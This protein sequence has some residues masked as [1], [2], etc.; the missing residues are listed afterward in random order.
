MKETE[1]ISETNR[2]WN[3]AKEN[4][5]NIA[6]KYLKELL[7]KKGFRESFVEYFE[8]EIEGGFYWYDEINTNSFAV[9]FNNLD[10]DLTLYE[11]KIY[12]K[13]HILKHLEERCDWAMDKE[14]ESALQSERG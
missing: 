4:I 7:L 13:S 12:K 10:A 2:I 11:I 8:V 14:A 9:V 1:F 5:E 3:K 6:D